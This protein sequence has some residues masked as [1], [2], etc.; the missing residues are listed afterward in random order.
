MSKVGIISQA[1]MT[2]TRLPGK[3][4][5]QAAGAPMLQHHI[6]RLE[7]AGAP[8]YLAT[9]ERVEDDP[10]E[11]F[12][13]DH[14][15]SFFRGDENDVLSRFYHLATR[16]SLD[17]IVRVTSDC[18]LIDGVLVEEGIQRFLAERDERMYLSICQQRTFP[19]GMDFEI[20]SYQLLA[21][22]QREAV[23]AHEREHVMPYFYQGRCDCRLVHITQESD[24]SEH[25]L[26]LDTPADYD[27]LKLLIEQYDAL[28]LDH[29][30]LSGLL[31]QHP[32][33][34]GLNSDVKQKKVP[35]IT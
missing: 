1:R 31:L 27:L 2:S 19:I 10:L 9:T 4:L 7:K 35:T 34:R 30:G 11:A 23:H 3:V 12:A 6:K 21:E 18:P 28:S 13:R 17:V 24:H 15:L 16:E 22:A 26:T 25:R 8:V 33:L 20:I 14:Q 5:L 29:A 32:E